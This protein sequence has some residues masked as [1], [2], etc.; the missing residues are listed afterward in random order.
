MTPFKDQ[1]AFLF[2]GQG[3]QSIGMGKQ[4]AETYPIAKE[5]FDQ[6]DQ[7]LGV[8]LTRIAWDDPPDQLNDTVNTQPALFV[9]SIAS[10]R[11]L[12]EYFPNLQPAFV[13]GH[14]MGELT[15]LVSAGSLDFE[16][17][18]SLVRKRGELMKQ[19]GE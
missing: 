5:I 1:V 19:A 17:G 12:Q 7:L 2:P 16:A 13:A 9:H 6:A 10:L 18:L 4:L 8:P 15:A 11:V 14:S 3:S